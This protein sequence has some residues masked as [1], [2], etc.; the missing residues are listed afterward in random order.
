MLNPKS[1]DWKEVTCPICGVA[2][3]ESDLARQVMTTGITAACTMCALKLG[4]G[5]KQMVSI[6]AEQECY[7]SDVN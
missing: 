2:C 4:N 5:G 1:K 6:P 3:W 7:L